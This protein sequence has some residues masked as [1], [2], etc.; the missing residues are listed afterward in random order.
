MDIQG[1]CCNTNSVDPEEKYT[2]ISAT[3]ITSSDLG[4]SGNDKF[5]SRR[6]IFVAVD[7]TGKK[8]GSDRTFPRHL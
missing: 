6:R 4:L 1:A 5:S 8:E 7:L 3:E 2:Q